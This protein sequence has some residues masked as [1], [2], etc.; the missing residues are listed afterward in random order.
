MI[1]FITNKEDITTDF[2]INRLNKLKLPYYRL[3]TED[4]LT[5]VGINFDFTND[6]YE[7]IDYRKNQKFNLANIKSVYYRRPELPKIA[8]SELSQG[9][10]YFVINELNYLLEGLYKLLQY[11]IWISSV[12]AIREAENKIYQLIVA[13]KLGFTIPLS[14]ITTIEESAKDFVER[15]NENCVIKAI[16]TGFVND[17]VEPKIIFTSLLKKEH[18]DSLS[19]VRY[20]PM[21][22]Q[23]KIDKI[24]DI[25]ITVVGNKVFPAKIKSQEF[26]ETKID[27][28]KGSNPMV[29]FER[30][31]IPEDLKLKCLNLTKYL[32]LNFGAID[33]ILDTNNS[34]TFLEI[35][36][37][38]QWAWIEKRLGYDISGEIINILLG[39]N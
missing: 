9:E 32:H 2:I 26:D 36:P 19:T 14:L 1:L 27:W 39:K 22:F 37:N 34:Y 6:I 4:I 17:E 13:R 30:I 16:K 5:K 7:I 33:L 28:R 23:S 38:G 29:E 3:N 25:R 8:Y 10:N 15:R 31:D 11:K 24:V 18:L 20:C 35:N 12:Y 21:Y